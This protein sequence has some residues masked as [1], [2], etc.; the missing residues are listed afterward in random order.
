[1]PGKDE[2]YARTF[3]PAEVKTNNSAWLYA[4][5]ATILF[6]G[7]MGAEQCFLHP[8]VINPTNERHEHVD[9]GADDND[10]DDYN[11]ADNGTVIKWT[12]KKM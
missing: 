11:D 2:I 8:I 1:M 6:N 3:L 12:K 5:E 4:R 9:D 10:G 7:G